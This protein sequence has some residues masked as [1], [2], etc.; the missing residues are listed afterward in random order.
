M[1]LRVLAW[2]LTSNN[3][4]IAD[5]YRRVAAQGVAVE[6]F[7]PLHSWRSRADVIHVHWPDAAASASSLARAVAKTAAVLTTLTILKARGAAVV[8]TC[9]NLSSHE[10]TH[11]RLDRFLDRRF[12]NL[13]DGTIHLTEASQSILAADPVLGSRPATVVPHGHF[14]HLDVAAPTKPAARIELGLDPE[15]PTIGFVGMIRPYKNVP[16]L[17]RTFAELS[18]PCQLVVGGRPLDAAVA[19]EVHRAAD[20]VPGLRLDTRWL[21]DAEVATRIRAADVVVLPYEEVHNSGVALLALGLDRPVAVN[22][23]G[24]MASLGDTVGPE[25]VH[26]LE[27]PLTSEQLAEVVRWAVGERPSGPDLSAFDPEL[28]ATRTVDFYRSLVA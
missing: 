22:P 25:W 10:A 19:S 5:L 12:K 8:W 7:R 21:S 15:R 17:I 6:E 13:V 20:G 1:T 28:A 2:P 14:G 18:E 9:H 16:D 23:S 27:K 24:S 26:H 11:P 4:Y 3:P